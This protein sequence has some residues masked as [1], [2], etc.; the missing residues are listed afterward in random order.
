VVK[1]AR[2]I[3]AVPGTTGARAA[4][5]AV[6]GTIGA[7]EAGVAVRGII[8]AAAAPAP[9]SIS[10]AYSSVSVTPEATADGTTVGNTAPSVTRNASGTT[11]KSTAP[12]AREVTASGAMAG[13]T[14]PAGSFA[15]RLLALRA[16]DA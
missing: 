3:F 15:V 11:T 12:T 13:D 4:G 5:T 8:G 10:A 9:A 6:R 14:A 16:T 7:M 1:T 2:E